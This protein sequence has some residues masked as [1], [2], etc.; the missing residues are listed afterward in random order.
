MVTPQFD[1]NPK[2]CLKGRRSILQAGV[3]NAMNV[4][5]FLLSSLFM[6]NE[7]NGLLSQAHLLPLQLHKKLLTLPRTN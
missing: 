5:G 7:A 4:C 2:E 1:R 3:V 6:E